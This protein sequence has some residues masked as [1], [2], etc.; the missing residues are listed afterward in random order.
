MVPFEACGGH[1]GAA[2]PERPVGRGDGHDSRAGARECRARL[3][4]DGGCFR[5]NVRCRGSFFVL[6]HCHLSSEGIYE[7]YERSPI[8]FSE[9]MCIW[10]G[11]GERWRPKSVGRLGIK[12]CRVLLDCSAVSGGGLVCQP[13]HLGTGWVR[14]YRW[15]QVGSGTVKAGVSDCKDWARH[16]RPGQLS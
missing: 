8:T 1:P 14:R 4:L 13:R 6:I 12:L 7:F 10:L 16:R 2:A 11:R 5:W 3:M 15:V 9:G